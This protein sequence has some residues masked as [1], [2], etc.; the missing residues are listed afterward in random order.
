MTCVGLRADGVVSF[1]TELM[2]E[3]FTR[4]V[5]KTHICKEVITDPE[6]GGEGAGQV[7]PGAMDKKLN[8]PK[9]KRS[10]HGKETEL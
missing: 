7:N 4:D 3:M 8:N 9:L 5:K 6:E 2:E 1:R 10:D